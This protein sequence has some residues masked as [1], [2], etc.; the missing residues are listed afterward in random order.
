MQYSA[1]YSRVS[2]RTGVRLEALE[3][4]PLGGTIFSGSTADNKIQDRSVLRHF[5]VC[6]VVSPADNEIQNGFV[7]RHC[8]LWCC[9]VDAM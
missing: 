2:V 6:E 5:C 9:A 4:L 3:D 1:M 7:L 8:Y